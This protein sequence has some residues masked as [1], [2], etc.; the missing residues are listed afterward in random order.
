MGVEKR[1]PRCVGVLQQIS[2]MMK[3]M[4]D[5]EAIKAKYSEES[6]EEQQKRKR[7]LLFPA[8]INF[9]VGIAMLVVGIVYDDEDKNGSATNFLMV[10]GGVLLATNLI[11]LV[12]YATPCKGDDKV[13]DV[14]TPILDLAYFI[15]VI[16]G[17]VKV[18][19]AYSTW[20]QEDETSENYCPGTPFYD[21][22]CDINLFLDFISSNV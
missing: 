18:F 11:K 12:A 13:A 8:F 22:I 15:I 1:P 10:G 14:I 6:P 20:T 4:V 7:Q 16:W 5:M 9:A 17:S 2:V 21:G 3:N 19:G